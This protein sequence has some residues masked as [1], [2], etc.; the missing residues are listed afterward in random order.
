MTWLVVGGAGY[1][2]SHVVHH[3]HAEGKDV[4]VLDDLSSGRAESVPSGVPLLVADAADAKQVLG[5]M[6]SRSVTGVIHLAARK[7]ARESMT[8]PLG[9]WRTNLGTLLGVLESAQSWPIKWI[10]LSSSCSVY[11]SAGEVCDETP[12]A[13]VSPYGSTK[14]ASEMLVRE[15]AQSRSVR[16]AA[17]RYFN[18]IGNAEFPMAPD[19]SSECIVPA[20]TRRLRQGESPVVFGGDFATPDGSAMRDY[21]DVRDVA[22]AHTVVATHLDTAP[23]S[24]YEGFACNVS[25]GTPVSVYSIVDSL[26][27]ATG[28]QG[29]VRTVDR[30]SG[31]PDLVWARPSSRLTA[32]GWRPSFSLVDSVLSHVLHDDSPT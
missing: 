31:D 26:A 4:V 14:V 12:L 5:V 11:G 16:W 24:H 23:G 27:S 17:L 6:G 13:P 10:L 28:W 30:R 20:V 25:T 7:H 22:A 21:I 19:R 32:L 9:Y 3:L 29:T 8:H 1:V 18:V 15:W 2:G